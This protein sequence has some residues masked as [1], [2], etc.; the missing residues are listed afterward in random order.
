MPLQQEDPEFLVHFIEYYIVWILGAMKQDDLMQKPSATNQV[1]TDK[2]VNHH[3][4]Y[5]SYTTQT[6]ITK[7]TNTNF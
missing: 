7:K 6:E 3:N 2:H 1:D 4:L 5:M